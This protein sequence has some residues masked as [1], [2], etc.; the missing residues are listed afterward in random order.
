MHDSHQ[1]PHP[2]HSR[3]LNRLRRVQ[4]Q[5]AGLEKMITDRRYCLDILIQFRAVSAAITAIEG[6]VLEKHIR[7]CVQSVLQTK[8]K[9]AADAKIE[10]LMKLFLKR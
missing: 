7:S 5:L 10:E 6:E 4:G 1:D 3:Q 2:D 8:N 9:T